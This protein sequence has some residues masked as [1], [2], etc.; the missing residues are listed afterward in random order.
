MNWHRF[1]R[2]GLAFIAALWIWK[3]IEYVGRQAGW[4]ERNLGW[5]FSVDFTI[6]VIATIAFL[7]IVALKSIVRR[8]RTN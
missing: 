8:F 6:P 2:I 5:G 7:S 4:L 3:V 1:G